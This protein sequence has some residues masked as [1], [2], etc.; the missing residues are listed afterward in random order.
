[1]AKKTFTPKLVRDKIPDLMR[2]DGEKPV[3]R[4][5]NANEMSTALDAKMIEENN[6]YL[7]ALSP[8]HKL[9]EHADILEVTFARAALLGKKPEDLLAAAQQKRE[10]KGGFTQNLFIDKMKS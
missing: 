9:G 3:V 5:L 4:V 7:A 8:D 6:E 2:A 10:A 1:M